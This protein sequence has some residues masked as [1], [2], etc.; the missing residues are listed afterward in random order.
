MAKASDAERLLVPSRKPDGISAV[1]LNALFAMS[2][3]SDT[4]N[5]QD[6]SVIRKVPYGVVPI[7]LLL[8]LLLGVAIY[9][10]VKYGIGTH[11]ESYSFCETMS[12]SVY[13]R[14]LNS[15]IN[16]RLHPCDNFYNHVCDGW[17]KGQSKSVY[18][19]HMDYFMDVLSDTLMADV[20]LWGQ[21][22]G[23]K[24]ACFFQSCRKASQQGPGNLEGFRQILDESQIEWPKLSKQP[25][26]L[27]SLVLLFKILRVRNI[28]NIGKRGPEVVLFGGED[29][30]SNHQHRVDLIR[31]RKMGSYEWYYKQTQSALKARYREDEFV[32]YSKFAETED[33]ILSSLQNYTRHN[34]TDLPKN[35]RDLALLT[36][37]ISYERWSELVQSEYQL[38][39]DAPVDLSGENIDYIR[40]FSKLLSTVGE[41]YLHYEIGWVMVQTCAP[42]VNRELLDI[43]YGDYDPMHPATE[44]GHENR[45][46]CLLI[47]EV[48]MGWAIY[49]KFFKGYVPDGSVAD[50]RNIT[51]DI[52]HAAFDKTRIPGNP[53]SY[54][55]FG[56][57][58]RTIMKYEDSYGDSDLLNI[59][60]SNISD[61]GPSFFSNWRVIVED[62]DGYSNRSLWQMA[63]S[64]FIGRAIGGKEGYT[65]Y[66]GADSTFQLPPYAMTLPLYTSDIIESVKY[67]ALGSL[68]G[69]AALAILR[70][71]TSR[72]ASEACMKKPFTNDEDANKAVLDAAASVRVA[73]DAYRGSTRSRHDV[74]L[75]GAPGFSSDQIF[76][77]STCYIL[78]GQPVDTY[79]D[80][81]CNEAL[82]NHPDFSGIFS[83]D[84]NAAMNPR[85]KCTLFLN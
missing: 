39:A 83:C 24:A 52:G 74:R 21:S 16:Q 33:S 50:I 58:L 34:Y 29:M 31:S 66:D 20:P 85:E 2:P 26:A 72:N 65:L 63:S 35:L 53:N 82:K 15:A 40:A 69:S 43:Y 14:A 57:E 5:R 75:H 13:E 71:N 70:Y 84:W 51:D 45:K 54:S 8:L 4:T 7:F 32:P 76:F 38:P 42:F 1:Q 41:Q 62:L 27:R 56:K 25:D 19:H 12:C 79:P 30:V 64:Y 67:A 61:M 60:F 49:R 18:R 36:E 55:A 47:T 3:P 73:W 59:T 23:D 48:F 37:G 78:C 22:P 44:A 9:F 46:R 81:R 11:D 28:V 10:A 68:I 17:N 80:V 77:V 6:T